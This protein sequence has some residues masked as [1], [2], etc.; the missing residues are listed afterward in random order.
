MYIGVDGCRGGW[1]VVVAD[2]LR[3][4]PRFA[5]VETLE[6]VVRTAR[7]GRALVVVD[8][9]IGLP[10]A[11]SR[12]CDHEARALLGP[13]QASSVFPAPTRPALAAAHDYRRACR[14]NASACGRRLS[15]QSFNLLRRIGHVDALIRPRLQRRVREG[16]PELVFHQLH[17][18]VMPAAKATVEGQRLRGALLAD[19]GVAFDVDAVRDKLVRANAAID[20][21]LDAAACLVA[22]RRI[23]SGD[24]LV[25]PMA[26]TERDARGLRMEIVA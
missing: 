4:A 2:D 3:D 23:A 1:V 25:L 9:P 24:A 5:V 22:A 6:D 17:A 16:H 13:R 15:L 26:G 20:D 8:I 12:R 10:Q 21:V 18:G 14:L 7:L 11:A 19:A